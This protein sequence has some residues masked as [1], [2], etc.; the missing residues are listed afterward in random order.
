M[1][2]T[3]FTIISLLIISIIF[4]QQMQIPATPKNWKQF[5]FDKKLKTSLPELEEM[6][7]EKVILEEDYKNS[8]SQT[9]I[10]YSKYYISYSYTPS[11]S[12]EGS[13]FSYD[14]MEG[15]KKIKINNIDCIYYEG[16]DPDPNSDDIS[17]YY[18]LII[19]FEDNY[20][21]S[22]RVEILEINKS[23]EQYYKDMAK[24]I[25]FSFELKE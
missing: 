4:G 16:L 20:V 10:K 25:L 21:Y 1:K 9:L 15:F 17:Q 18:L 14:N 5:T 11:P 23:K 12:T 13:Y 3:I 19:P 8:K 22:I 6:K 2:K 24:K 7:I